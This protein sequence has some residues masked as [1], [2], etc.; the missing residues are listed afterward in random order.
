MMKITFKLLSSKSSKKDYNVMIDG[1]NFFNQP[2]NNDFKTYENIR[3]IATGQG[4][5]STTGC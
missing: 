4:G 1:K 3:K 5:D 2:I